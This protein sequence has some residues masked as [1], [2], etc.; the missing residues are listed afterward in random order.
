MGRCVASADACVTVD[1]QIFDWLVIQGSPQG[2]NQLHSPYT[3]SL[4][5]LF[6]STV[7]FVSVHNE[8]AAL[9]LSAVDTN[10]THNGCSLM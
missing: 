1:N 6:L 5:A 3:S 2:G 9:Q 8:H 7:D 10:A 4:L